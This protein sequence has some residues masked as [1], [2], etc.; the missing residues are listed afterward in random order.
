MK[1]KADQIKFVIIRIIYII[2]VPIILYDIILISQ[3]IIN[4]YKTPSFFGYKTFNI[5]SGSMEPEIKINDVVITREAKDEE[6]KE[7]DIITYNIDGNIVTHRIIKKE[8]IDGQLKYTTKGDRNDVSDID[9]ITLDQIEGIYA[10]KIPGIG[11]IFSLL[12]NKAVFITVLI[13]LVV[14]FLIEKKKISNKIRRKEKRIKWDK[15]R[16]DN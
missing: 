7:G 5:I 13:I 8:L 1:T 3:T 12:K 11:W 10:G 4:P 9:K 2:V 6:L 16:E 14:C 15:K